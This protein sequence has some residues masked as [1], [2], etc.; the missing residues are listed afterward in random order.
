MPDF[1]VIFIPYLETLVSLPLCDTEVFHTTNVQ[2]GM[3]P[4]FSS[5]DAYPRGFPLNARG[6]WGNRRHGRRRVHGGY[7]GRYYFGK[8]NE[9]R[10]SSQHFFEINTVFFH[11]VPDRHAVDIENAGRLG[12]VAVALPQGFNQHPFFFRITGIG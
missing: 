6:F 9:M 5:V 4:L 1:S 7:I 3:N 2:S 11:A 8:N 12:L 10:S